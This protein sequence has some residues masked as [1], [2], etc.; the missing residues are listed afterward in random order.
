MACS[1]GVRLWSSISQ[2]KVALRALSSSAT[3]YRGDTNQ[4]PSKTSS[5][6]QKVRQSFQLLG[7]TQDKCSVEDV[8]KAYILLAKKYHPDSNSSEEATEQF[9]RVS[10]DYIATN[11]YAILFYI[12]GK[13]SIQ[14][15]YKLCE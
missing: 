13:R 15:V 12:L 1:L 11:N 10:V 4:S 5:R 8:R 3:L 6:S 2:V 7:L 14:A 9:I